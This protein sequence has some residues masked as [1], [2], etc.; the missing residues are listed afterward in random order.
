MLFIDGL[1]HAGPVL[2]APQ[3]YALNSSTG[4]TLILH[5]KGEKTEAKGKGTQVK[6]VMVELDK[7]ALRQCCSL[8]LI[9]NV[10]NHK[11]RVVGE[12]RKCGDPGG[13]S[14]NSQPLRPS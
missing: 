3:T 7:R 11:Y 10:T 14:S 6:E 8:L 1:P 12:E 2:N 9:G 4:T 5:F 13:S